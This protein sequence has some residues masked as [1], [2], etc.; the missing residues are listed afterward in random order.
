MKISTKYHGNIEVSESDI[1]TF[2]NGIPGFLDEKSFVLLPLDDESPFTILQS[3]I[4]AELGFIIVNPFIFFPTYEF[5][6]SD[7]EKQLLNLT[8]EK[9]VNVFTILNI[10]DP[11]QQST[12][13]L[14]AP[15]I[16]NTKNNKAKQIILNDARYKTKHTLIQE[17]IGK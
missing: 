13:N 3:T 15:I 1:V 11:F 9:D 14:Q 4:T 5:E 6:L 2:E 12:A 17:N 7:N 8:S 16:L 10:K